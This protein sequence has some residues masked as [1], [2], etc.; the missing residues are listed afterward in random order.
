[1]TRVE[2]AEMAD[3]NFVRSGPKSAPSLLFLHAIGMDLTWW[4]H[5]IAE[6]AHHYDVI[7]LDLPGHGLSG[8]LDFPTFDAMAQVVA[9]L[10]EHVGVKAAHAVGLSMSGMIAQTLAIKRPD[11]VCSLSLISTRSTFPAAG[12]EA[13]SEFARIARQDGMPKMAQLLTERMFPEPFRVLRPDVLDR[14]TKALLLQDKNFHA[15]IWEMISTF[16]VE[17]QLHHITCPTLVVIGAEDI[18]ANQEAGKN[19][20]RKISGAVLHEVPGAGHL[21]PV[22][23]PEQFNALLRSFL[24]IAATQR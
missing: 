11:L 1:M 14:I 19:L 4:E 24:T 13:M 5:Q 9:G 17:S 18:Q 10:L 8:K 6:F 20:A 23:T 22:Q 2:I 16:D 21:P 12:R 7:A 15:S 3:V